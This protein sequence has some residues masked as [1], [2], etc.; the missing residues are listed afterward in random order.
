MYFARALP[1]LLTLV[2]CANARKCTVIVRVHYLWLNAFSLQGLP[3]FT[4]AQFCE[5]RLLAARYS[6]QVFVHRFLH[7][8][9]YRLSWSSSVQEDDVEQVQQ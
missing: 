6:Q 9:E 5:N 8:A 2:T 7:A 3:C 1:L 4:L